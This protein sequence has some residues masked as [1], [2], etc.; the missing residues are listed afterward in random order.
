MR[1]LTRET[2]SLKQPKKV[3]K[4]KEKIQR[5]YLFF[6][7]AFLRALLFDSRKRGGR[8]REETLSALL[9]HSNCHKKEEEGAVVAGAIE[10]V[11]V[12]VVGGAVV[13]V[14]KPVFEIV[15]VTAAGC[16]IMAAVYS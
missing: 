1:P 9:S 7:E 4:S 11:I 6:S 10:V 14:G 12:V 5:K 3:N 2:P 13:T 15:P 8:R 16:Q